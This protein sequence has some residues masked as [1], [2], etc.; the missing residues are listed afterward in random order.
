VLYALEAREFVSLEPG[1]SVT[2]IA[3]VLQFPALL[4]Q[5]AG[6]GL[7]PRRSG[8]AFCVAD[9]MR[10]DVEQCALFV[11][12]QLVPP[13]GVLSGALVCS[14]HQPERIA[15]FTRAA[16]TTS[17]QRIVGQTTLR[18]HVTPPCAGVV[19]GSARMALDIAHSDRGCEISWSR[20]EFVTRTA[21]GVQVA[22]R[23][24][25]HRI[26]P[27]VRRPTGPRPCE[28]VVEIDATAFVDCEVGMAAPPR[29][30]G[31]R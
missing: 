6:V 31:P 24:A 22:D 2:A 20:T 8:N 10:V 15:E 26:A 4:I 19:V 30:A 29:A 5:C 9:L 7:V 23:D 17:C 16:H 14:F 12:R 11:A 1:E 28:G 27:P 3:P 18:R 25:G 21:V 13:S